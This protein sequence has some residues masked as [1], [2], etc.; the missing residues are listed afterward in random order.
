VGLWETTL[1][2]RGY[3]HA[4][5]GLPRAVSNFAIPLCTAPFSTSVPLPG[6]GVAPRVESRANSVASTPS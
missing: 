3:S 2:P 5:K 1:R 6:Q 4:L